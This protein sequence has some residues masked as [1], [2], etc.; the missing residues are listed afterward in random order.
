MPNVNGAISLGFELECVKLYSSARTIIDRE[1]FSLHYDRSIRGNM[2]E[3]LPRTIEQGG[4]DEIVTPIYYVEA[5]GDNCGHFQMDYKDV[6]G[7][8]QAMCE[9]AGAVNRSCGLHIHLGRPTKENA[10]KSKW[11]PQQ[12]RT[13]IN[14]VG[15]PLEDRLFGVMPPSR[16][17][18]LHCARIKTKYLDKDLSQFYPVGRVA[19]RKYDNPKRYCWMNC[20]ETTRQ[21][22]DPTPGH[23]SSPALGT[24]E[25]RM[26]GNT[27]RVEYI[28]EWTKMWAHIAAIVAYS[29][30]EIVMGH[31][32]G[33]T[34]EPYITRLS[35][36]RKTFDASFHN[37]GPMEFVS[38]EEDVT[39]PSTRP[40]VP[41]RRAAPL[42]RRGVMPRMPRRA[43]STT[44]VNEVAPASDYEEAL[45]DSP[46]AYEAAI[47]PT[48][49][50]NTGVANQ[51]EI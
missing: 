26:M 5:H 30:P 39:L 38:P 48:Q 23:A 49:P 36:I 29:T 7:R 46:A 6:L 50:E 2:G 3:E 37:N 35:D 33:G 14:C 1:H 10:A 22:N 19:P 18:N 21:G 13:M 12:V 40:V 25:I 44:I 42:P 51:E 31:I 24:I 15:L 34:F 4:G 28:W 47:R 45:M 32:W 43:E 11:S 8:I 41:L 16:I 20:I 9:A 17:N 27:R